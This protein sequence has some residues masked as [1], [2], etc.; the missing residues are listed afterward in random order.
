MASFDENDLKRRFNFHPADGPTGQV[1]D[2]VRESVYGCAQDL[3]ELVP[4]G[5]ELS[6]VLTSLEEAMMWGNAGVAR[7]AADARAL[8]DGSGDVETSVVSGDEEVRETPEE[9][10]HRLEVEAGEEDAAASEVGF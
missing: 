1:H 2:Q 8:D 6:L 9:A 3:C 4:A 5:R 7:A 10:K